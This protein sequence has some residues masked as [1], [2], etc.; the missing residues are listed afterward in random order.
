MS[1]KD[2]LKKNIFIIYSFFFVT[3]FFFS[4]TEKALAEDFLTSCGLTKNDIKNLHFVLDNGNS[5]F[6]P[7]EIDEINNETF[8]QALY[9]TAFQK[10]TSKMPKEMVNIIGIDAIKTSHHFRPYALNYILRQKL[11]EEDLQ[12]QLKELKLSYDETKFILTNRYF[13]PTEYSNLSKQLL[14][15]LVMYQI[16]D[17]D[18]ILFL[19][20]KFTNLITDKMLL[21]QVRFYIFGNKTKNLQALGKMI[22]DKTYKE[23]Y[24]VL[25]NFF[26]K[27]NQPVAKKIKNKNGKIITK[28]KKP[29]Y[30]QIMKEC[31]KYAK[32][33]QVI[34]LICVNKNAK[35]PKYIEKI[36]DNYNEINVL[37]DKWLK[38]IQLYARDEIGNNEN[39]QNAYNKITM[40]VGLQ[41]EN[42]YTQ[43][44]LAGFIAYLLGNYSNASEH[45]E[46]CANIATK[47]LSIAKAYYWLGLSYR[48]QNYENLSID[49]FK[50]A[51]KYVFTM[52]GQLASSELNESAEENIEQHIQSQDYDKKMLCNDL[53]FILGYLEQL[54]SKKN[55]LSNELYSYINHTNDEKKLFNAILILNNDFDYLIAK[56]FAFYAINHNVA[57]DG[58]TFPSANTDVSG[59]TNAVIKKESNFNS[60]MIG[61]AGERG[62][63]QIMPSTAKIL[64]KEM[65]IHFDK[66]KLLTSEDYNVSIGNY[67]LKKLLYRFDDHKVLALSAYNAGGTNV[68]K[69]IAKNGDPRDM[70]TNEEN[71][72]WIEKIPFAFTREYVTQILG[73]EMAYDVFKKIRKNNENVE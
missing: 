39:L 28:Y 71:V 64:A 43:Q 24:R 13:Q 10:N 22:N 21:Q 30:Q 53:N 50:Q 44:F 41:K 11:S 7:Y 17:Y 35:N 34:G 45:F 25:L 54:K 27:I 2:F 32:Y 14:D 49:A 59:L 56:A 46:K 12:K 31:E 60:M 4:Q 62:L 3:N 69:W 5:M 65:N 23:Q 15:D 72:I 20:K 58:I 61:L 19:Q 6:I 66:K 47:A 67:F 36:L 73:I 51:K 38:H 55:I 63:M 33:D 40:L 1:F 57:L 68:A 26:N 29:T 9:L 37:S 8:K 42:F 16:L 52:Y 18:D 70:T 48:H